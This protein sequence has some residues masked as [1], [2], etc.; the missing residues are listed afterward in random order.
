M[1]SHDDD[2]LFFFLGFCLNMEGRTNYCDSCGTETQGDEMTC[3]SKWCDNKQQQSCDVVIMC[4]WCKNIALPPS[5]NHCGSQRCKS[6]L[7]TCPEIGCKKT[8]C[9][10]CVSIR[11]PC[12]FKPSKHV[13]TIQDCVNTTRCKNH[14]VP[15]RMREIGD[16]GDFVISCGQ[17]Q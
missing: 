7:F 16:D 12:E 11:G 2:L 17:H 15:L 13:W 8:I 4:R 3:T 14:Y 5:C 6:C 9:K 1:S 10:L